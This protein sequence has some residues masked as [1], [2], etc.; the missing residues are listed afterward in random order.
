M[1]DGK[2]YWLMMALSI[3]VSMMFWNSDSNVYHFQMGER[4]FCKLYILLTEL[5]VSVFMSLS[6]CKLYMVYHHF[7]RNCCCNKEYLT[8]S[9]M[10]TPQSSAPLIARSVGPTWGSSGSRWAPCWTHE[11]CNRGGGK[12]W[13]GSSVLLWLHYVL[14]LFPTMKIFKNI[15]DGCI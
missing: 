6:T 5:C 4:F 8:A 14:F 2:I 11:P 13:G 9:F 7:C 3:N 1:E 15:F 12:A 10:M